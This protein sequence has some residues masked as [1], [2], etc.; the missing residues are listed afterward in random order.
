LMPPGKSPNRSV[1]ASPSRRH[2]KHSIPIA[3]RPERNEIKNPSGRAQTPVLAATSTSFWD[4]SVV[5][6]GSSTGHGGG[7]SKGQNAE[8][9]AAAQRPVFR[10]PL[11]FVV[12]KARRRARRN[13]RSATSSE[14]GGT[15]THPAVGGIHVGVSNPPTYQEF[16]S[17]RVRR[18]KWMS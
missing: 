18:S 11:L 13:K 8:S 17:S 6:R 15:V 2:C 12:R 10:E 16:A 7:A 9:G 14:P 5:G 1:P 4:P 3:T